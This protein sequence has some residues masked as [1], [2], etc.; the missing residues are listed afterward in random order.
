MNIRVQYALTPDDF[1]ELQMA[2]RKHRRSLTPKGKANS[3]GARKLVGWGVIIFTVVAGVVISN[4]FSEP[5]PTPAA[6]NYDS[7]F[8]LFSYLALVVI[9]SI[10]LIWI[11]RSRFMYRR[12]A[13]RLSRIGEA[14][15]V[16]M[17]NEHITIRERSCVSVMDWT[18][19]IRFIETKSTFLLF[20]LPQIPADRANPAQTG[21][22]FGWRR[23]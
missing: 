7:F 9:I 11:C 14:R 18:Y 12:V 6:N 2:Y 17:T 21:V 16:E 3:L 10:F 22:R 8:A 5:A 15:T 1:Y 13:G 23:G 19:F 4:A 20:T